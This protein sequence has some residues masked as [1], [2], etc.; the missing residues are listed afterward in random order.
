M[1]R[2]GPRYHLVY[3]ARVRQAKLRERE[4]QFEAIAIELTDYAKPNLRKA[5]QQKRGRP[6]GPPLAIL[7]LMAACLTVAA[8]LPVAA[9][10]GRQRRQW[11]E[12]QQHQGYRAKHTNRDL[13]HVSS[14]FVNSLSSN[15]DT[16]NVSLRCQTARGELLV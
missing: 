4:L 13:L 1:Q 14:P 10:A 11:R 15:S 8:G 12:S 9:V 16:D 2:L 5:I 6:R 7:L 3:D